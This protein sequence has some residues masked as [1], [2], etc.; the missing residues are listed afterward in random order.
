MTEPAKTLNLELVL[1]LQIPTEPVPKDRPRVGPDGGHSTPRTKE[2]EADIRSRVLAALGR[3]DPDDQYAYH[4]HAYFTTHS[5]SKDLDNL[6]KLVMDALNGYVWKDDRQV[7][8]IETVIHRGTEQPMT[9]LFI[10]R[11]NFKWDEFLPPGKETTHASTRRVPRTAT[12]VQ[13]ALRQIEKRASP[14]G[15]R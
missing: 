15:R 14:R 2:G 9:Q 8:T 3:I 5:R 7:S 6:V 10:Y 11:S 13:R 4:L 12:L 1:S